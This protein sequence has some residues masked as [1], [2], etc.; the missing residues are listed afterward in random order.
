MRRYDHWQRDKT[1]ELVRAY[2]RCI[3]ELTHLMGL[4]GKKVAFFQNLHKDVER[5]ESQDSSAGLEPDCKQGETSVDR[6]IFAEHLMAT[7]AEHCKDLVADLRH[8][9]NSVRFV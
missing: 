4:L 9:L 6:V 8:A 5:F 3:D 1:I 7:S 2:L